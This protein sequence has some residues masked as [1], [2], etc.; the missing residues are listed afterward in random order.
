MKKSEL[1]R[2]IREEV[3]NLTEMSDYDESLNP[4]L[5]PD[6]SEEL[7][8]KLNPKEWNEFFGL[9]SELDELAPPVSIENLD[10]YF[11]LDELEDAIDYFEEYIKYFPPSS[12]V[13]K[14]E[15]MLKKIK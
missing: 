13:D 11:P 4:I 7:K 15:K 9:L 1:K 12:T 8:E 3:K 2:M 10:S 14:F 6:A 5:E